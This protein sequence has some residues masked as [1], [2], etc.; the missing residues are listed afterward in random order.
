MLNEWNSDVGKLMGLIEKSCHLIAK[1]RFAFSLVIPS[2]DSRRDC[3]NMLCTLL[4][5]P[6]LC[7]LDLVLE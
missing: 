6:S 3:R 5:P 7:R 2:T 1:V 4:L